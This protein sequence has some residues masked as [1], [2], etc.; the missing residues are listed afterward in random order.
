MLFLEL[1]DLASP[2]ECYERRESV[3]PQQALALSNSSLSLSMARLLAKRLMQ[4][5]RVAAND[6][7]FVV[8]AFEQVLGRPPTTEEQA[9][10]ER[11]LREQ[12]ELLKNPAK[13]TA[14][15]PDPASVTPPST[16]SAQR[17]RENLVHVLFNH[18]DFI[19]VR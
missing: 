11:F 7:A 3:V 18:N 14:F 17:A 1:F 4:D 12:T 16:D 6:P 9:R 10:C 13:L 19:T 2:N 8:A 15:P 5:A